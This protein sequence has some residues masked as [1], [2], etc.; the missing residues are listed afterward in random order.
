MIMV[1]ITKSD[2]HGYNGLVKWSWSQWDSQTV[3]ITMA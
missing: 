3:K 1:R 2:L